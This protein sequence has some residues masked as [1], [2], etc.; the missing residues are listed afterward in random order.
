[1]KGSGL[2]RNYGFRRL[3]PIPQRFRSRRNSCRKLTQMNLGWWHLRL[4]CSAPPATE[5]IYT[6]FAHYQDNR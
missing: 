6:P 2:A 3:E 5:Q 4:E 1:M